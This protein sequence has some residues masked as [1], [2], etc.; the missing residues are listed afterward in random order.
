MATA[1]R[2]GADLLDLMSAYA[3]STKLYRSH[4]SAAREDYLK[5]LVERA[6]S[7]NKPS[8]NLFSHFTTNPLSTSS[9]L[10]ADDL[11]NYFISK[12][13]TLRSSPILRS[14]NPN[15][16]QAPASVPFESSMP[17]TPQT[18]IALMSSSRK[19]LSPRDVFPPSL[20]CDHI[21][22]IIGPFIH[23]FNCSLKS[24]CFL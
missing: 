14:S 1:R 20:L 15:V 9:S 4:L 13:G 18:M 11:A 10:S 3:Q 24:G 8:F 12:V 23:L 16:A 7:R 17:V 21:E 22:H 5:R 19:S 2:H 6:K